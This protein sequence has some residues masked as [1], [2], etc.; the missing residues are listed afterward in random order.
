MIF[1]K[2]RRSE[3]AETDI[4]FAYP[5]DTALIFTMH[6]AFGEGGRE[7]SRDEADC[8]DYLWIVLRL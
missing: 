8:T 1:V 3:E 4:A 7:Q 5:S 6:F 2:W